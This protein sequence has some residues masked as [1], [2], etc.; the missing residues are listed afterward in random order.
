MC[1]KYN[2]SYFSELIGLLLRYEARSSESVRFHIVM[3]KIFKVCRLIASDTN[4]PNSLSSKFLSQ[5]VGQ[6][7]LILS[8]GSV[9]DEDVSFVD[10]AYNMA[11][12]IAEIMGNSNF[13]PSYDT[14]E[15][16]LFCL[17]KVWFGLILLIL[18]K[19]GLWPSNWKS[20]ILIISQ[21]CPP[22]V[23]SKK[24]KSLDVDL[25]SCSLLQTSIPSDVFFIN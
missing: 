25:A 7:L 16:Y 18:N 6:L 4:L 23:I 1:L 24:A 5:I 20:L 2:T 9:R 3:L 15:N 10:R 14:D 22:L 11:L 21:K 13:H 8:R 19:D 12:V 17:R